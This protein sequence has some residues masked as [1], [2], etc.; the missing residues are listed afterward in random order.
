LNRRKLEERRRKRR[1]T[2]LGERKFEEE[3][4]ERKG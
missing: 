4:R 3:S 1:G 2:F